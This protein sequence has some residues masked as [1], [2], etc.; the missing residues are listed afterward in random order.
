MRSS[1]DRSDPRHQRGG[2]DRDDE[3]RGDLHAVRPLDD[4]DDG[5]V[6]EHQRDQHE[7]E[8]LPRLARQTQQRHRHRRRRHQ[9]QHAG[10]VGAAL[11]VDVGLEQQRDEEHDRR[12]EQHQRPR[13]LASIPA[14]CR[15]AA[16]IAAPGSAARPSP[17]RRRTTGSR[18]CSG[19]RRSRTTSP[20]RL[21]REIRE[22][23][24]RRRAALRERRQAES[25][26][27]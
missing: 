25:A 6:D 5:G 15:S 10:R 12:E 19:R 16:D 20:S 7:R 3:P 26:A 23:A 8:A 11:R 17:T 22:R 1:V 27:S 18:W 4:V 2:D 24:A 14:P 13:R 21:V 9:H